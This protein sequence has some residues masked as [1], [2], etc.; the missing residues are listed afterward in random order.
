MGRSL[1]PALAGH[2]THSN[3]MGLVEVIA[4]R[5]HFKLA[6][7]LIPTVYSFRLG[8]YTAYVPNAFSISFFSALTPLSQLLRRFPFCFD[9][10]S[11]VRVFKILV[12]GSYEING[13]RLWNTGMRMCWLLRPAL[14]VYSMAGICEWHDFDVGL[15]TVALTDIFSWSN[16][17]IS[18]LAMS[19]ASQK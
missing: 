3:P 12:W 17:L 8:E 1:F 4:S 2:S 6:P 14:G 11:N 7:S 18:W 13:G 15:R 10:D 19:M 16:F 5:S 9:D